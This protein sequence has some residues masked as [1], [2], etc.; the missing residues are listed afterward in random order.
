MDDFNNALWPQHLWLYCRI[1]PHS[2]EPRLIFWLV[3]I[4][5]SLLSLHSS[6]CYVKHVDSSSSQRSSAH[7]STGLLP[8]AVKA[9]TP[10]CNLPAPLTSTAKGKLQPG[11]CLAASFPSPNY[12]P[13]AGELFSAAQKR[14]SAIPWKFPPA[15]KSQLSPFPC[16]WPSAVSLPWVQPREPLTIPAQEGAGARWDHQPWGSEA[17]ETAAAPQGPCKLQLLALC[18]VSDSWTMPSLHCLT[19][20]LLCKANQSK[21]LSQLCC[22]AGCRGPKQP[23]ALC[24]EAAPCCLPHSGKIQQSNGNR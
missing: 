23:Q 14:S 24:M 13:H 6:P 20:R 7:P 5:T 1:S 3:S 21:L 19:K 22:T 10:T 11:P 16:C 9:S 2:E 15:W 18:S 17:L 8:R 12:S 4:T